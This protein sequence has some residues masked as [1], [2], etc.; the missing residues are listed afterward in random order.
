[1]H[2]DEPK[3]LILDI[4]GEKVVT[5]GDIITDSEVEIVNPE[6]HIATVNA[7][8]NFY[9]EITVETGRG[10]VLANNNKIPD[11][12]I[13]IIPVDSMFTPTRKVNFKVDNT[14]VGQITDF[15]KLT[16]ELWTNGSIKP[17][18]CLEVDRKLLLD[19]VSAEQ[20]LRSRRSIRTYKDKAVERE[21]I[22]KLID[23]ACHAPSGHNSQSVKWQV[24]HDRSEVKRYSGMVVDWMRY[25]IKEQPD[26][27]KSLHL[28]LV[29]AGWDFGMDTV[30]RDAP[31]LILANGN[32]N[33]I[34]GKATCTIAMTYLELALPSFGLGGCWNGFFNVAA[35]HWPPLQEALG[36]GEDTLNHG[37]MM[38][39][40][41]KY[42]YHRM[43]PRNDADITWK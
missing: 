1:M 4:K 31:H 2:T 34:M 20:F 37:V 28:D 30:S 43:P 21:T 42:K 29:V 10:Y 39:G 26:F 14:R 3:T 19:P 18:D 27:A 13:G 41:P 12:P 15:D 38:V 40:H 32:K 36:L 33:N 23:I 11:M 7:S 35:M 5:A 25:M 9:A 24:I 16:L 8:G 17:E 22:E 6:L